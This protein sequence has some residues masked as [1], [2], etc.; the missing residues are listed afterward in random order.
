MRLQSFADLERA[1]ASFAAGR[2]LSWPNL[3]TFLFMS[4]SM[5]LLFLQHGTYVFLIFQFYWHSVP[6]RI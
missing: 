3:R 5:L 6:G 4:A 2:S 1:E